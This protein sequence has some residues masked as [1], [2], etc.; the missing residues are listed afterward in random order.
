MDTRDT[1][2]QAELRRSARRLA[3][4][5]GPATVADL[6]DE[7][8]TKRLAGAVRDAGWLELRSDGGDGRPLAGGV[9][10]AIVAE[11]LAEA[12]ADVAFTGPVLA[13]DLA[14]RAGTN[15]SDGAVVGFSSSLTHP[16]VVAGD[17]TSAPV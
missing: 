14:R 12:V 2:E 6:A 7:T 3:H 1:P 8:R 15:A 11:S 17:A 10:A 13:A 9:E 16:A 5:L 4:E